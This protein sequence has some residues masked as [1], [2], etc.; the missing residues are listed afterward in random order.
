[1]DE[2]AS[3]PTPETSVTVPDV[4]E[5]AEIEA[6]GAL[7][8][9]QQ[10]IVQLAPPPPP[11]ANPA[12]PITKP[13]RLDSIDVLRGF[14]VLGIL[15]LNIQSFAMPGAAYINP[16]AYGSLEGANYWVWWCSHVFADQKFMTI[17]SMLFGAG[18]VIMTSRAEQR[19]GHSAAIHYR[20]MAWLILF[21]VLH[22]HLL[23]YGDI[24]Y[25]YGMCGLAV[26]LLR[27][28]RP[29]VLIPLGIA[30]ISVAFVISLL[31][32]WSMQF[33]GEE[34]IKGMLE[35]WQPSPETVQED[36]DAYRGPWLQQMPGRMLGAVFFQT[37]LFMIW[38]F[39]RAGGLMLIGMALFKLGVF[40]AARSRAFYLVLAL[41]GLAIGLP[42]AMYGIHQNNRHNWDITYSFFIGSQWNYWASLFVSVGYLSLVML[43]CKSAE[44]IPLTRPFAAVG[45][46]AFT[47]YLMQTIICTTIFYGHG[48]GLFGAVERTGQISIVFGVWIFQLIISPI[49]LKYFEFGPAEWLWRSLTYWKPQ[50]FLKR[51]GTTEN[52]EITEE[53]LG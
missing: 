23:W 17:F 12:A 32:G 11:P 37:M 20:R 48:L 45:R 28:W 2:N 36:L 52:T 15:I 7:L 47:N 9:E 6:T 40:S 43:L 53:R 38:S 5:A 25:A 3:T 16:R 34:A 39:W 33:W 35:G 44:F 50:P 10:R 41:L 49:W 13:E 27:K 18:I 46:M 31:S 21:G 1:M 4:G 22:A 24:L 30:M 19:T 14:A 42:L 29:I 51:A 26:W 8:V